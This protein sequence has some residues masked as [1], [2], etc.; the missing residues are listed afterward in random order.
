MKQ[1]C[2]CSR[3]KQASFITLVFIEN[4]LVVASTGCL[5]STRVGQEG[6][7]ETV[8]HGV[9]KFFTLTHRSSPRAEDPL[10]FAVHPLSALRLGC[11]IC[12]YAPTC[13]GVLLLVFAGFSLRSVCPT[14]PNDPTDGKRTRCHFSI[15]RNGQLMML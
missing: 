2:K 11:P 7:R 1:P 14:A 8:P 12:P 9:S 3:C 13:S 6:A 5:A 15:S 4:C 10:C